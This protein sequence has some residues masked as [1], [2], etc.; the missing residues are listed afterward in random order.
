MS[1][2]TLKTSSTGRDSGAG[3]AI[4]VAVGT[5]RA[6]V[7]EG[8]SDAAEIVQLGADGLLG[9]R[10]DRAVDIGVHPGHHL[11]RGR[12]ARPERVAHL[13]QSLVPVLAIEGQQPSGSVTTGPWPGRIAVT[14][15]LRTRASS[16]SRDWK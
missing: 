11:R 6:C 14:V 5:K 4:V 16:T 1:Q 8:W 13:V 2:Q 9:G 7:A 10:P 15:R 12:V 3:T